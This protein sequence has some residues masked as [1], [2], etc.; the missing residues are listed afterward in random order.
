MESVRGVTIELESF[1][2]RSATPMTPVLREAIA[3]ALDGL[4]QKYA[5]V[6]S[7]AG[8]DAMCLGTIVPTAM[9]FVPSIGGQSHVREERTA[10]RDLLLGVEALAA[11]IIEVDN[12]LEG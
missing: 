1:E 11:A 8:H 6:A 2:A 7:G 12:T 4:G 10:D 3:R 5:D 9:L